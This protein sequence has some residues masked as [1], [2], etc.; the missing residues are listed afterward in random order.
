[1]S[2]IFSDKKLLIR[3]LCIGV[4]LSLAITVILMCMLAVILQFI[5][6]IPYQWL[7]YILLVID[8]VAVFVGSYAAAAV[9]RSKGL[10]VGLFCG[11]AVFLIMYIA[12]LCSGMTDLS[13]LTALRALVMLV[14]GIFGGIRGVNKKEKIHIK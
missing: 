2:E 5:S 12:G 4:F 9:T 7:D 8:A 6:A 3:A 1:M 14:A 11:A 10:I 13:V